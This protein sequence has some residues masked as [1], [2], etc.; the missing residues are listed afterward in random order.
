MEI[1]IGINVVEIVHV[2]LVI[3]EKILSQK[4]SDM[5]KEI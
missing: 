3:N 1:T 4:N 5:K 2:Y